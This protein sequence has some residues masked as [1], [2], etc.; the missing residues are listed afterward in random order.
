MSATCGICSVGP[1]KYKCPLCRLPYCSTVCYK[2]HKEVPCSAPAPAEPTEPSAPPT[3][4]ATTSST[5]QPSTEEDE[6][7]LLTNEQLAVLSMSANLKKALHDPATRSKI[8]AIDAHPDRL[9]ELQKALTDPVFARFVYN[10]MD[11]VRA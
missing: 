1:R 6:V 10:M 5:G 9:Q 2:V 7:P 4:V 11:E 3:T 8:T